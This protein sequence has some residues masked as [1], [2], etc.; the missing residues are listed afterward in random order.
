MALLGL[1]LGFTFANGISHLD[2]RRV[3]IVQESNATK[4]EK[5]G[6][7]QVLANSGAQDAIVPLE[8]LSNDPAAEVS[9]EARRSLRNL[10]ARL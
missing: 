6:L 4:D 3:L 2:Q 5:T 10:R 7:A 8:A 1:L 9:Q